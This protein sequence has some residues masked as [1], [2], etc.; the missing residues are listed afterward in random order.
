[1]EKILNLTATEIG[2]KI[3]KGE[4]PNLSAKSW[5]KAHSD[6]YEI[7]KQLFQ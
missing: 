5:E 6:N 2:K 4:A 7:G 1:M 3:A